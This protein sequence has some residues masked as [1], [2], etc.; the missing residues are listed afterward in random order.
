LTDE[1]LRDRLAALADWVHQFPGPGAFQCCSRT[2]RP[3]FEW[4]PCDTAAGWELRVDDERG[5]HRAICLGEGSAGPW[6]NRKDCD[7]RASKETSPNRYV[8]ATVNKRRACNDIFDI[9]ALSLAVPYFDIVVTDSHRRHVLRT[10]H[11]PND[12]LDS[13]RCELLDRLRHQA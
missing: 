12:I 5:R 9:D 7:C 3:H 1:Q 11:L 4:I 10:A 13:A 8:I 2:D 6:T